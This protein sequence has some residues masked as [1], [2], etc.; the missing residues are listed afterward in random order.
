MS[1]RNHQIVTMLENYGSFKAGDR[2]R[3]ISKDFSGGEIWLYVTHESEMSDHGMNVPAERFAEYRDYKRGMQVLADRFMNNPTRRNS[4]RWMKGTG[5]TLRNKY[6]PVKRLSLPN[7]VNHWVRHTDSDGS[8][9]ILVWVFASNDVEAVRKVLG[10]VADVDGHH[11]NSAYDCTG[12]Y[13]SWA[14]D[15]KVFP[16]RIWVTQHWGLD[17]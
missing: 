7:L 1:K 4:Y 9:G 15:F 17:V 3:I 6:K 10:Q 11:I 13:F 5:N 16:N 2:C 12:K 14:C 8:S